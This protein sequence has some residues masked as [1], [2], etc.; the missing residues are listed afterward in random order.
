[1]A[2]QIHRRQFLAGSAT[3]AAAVV[4]STAQAFPDDAGPAQEFYEW[5]TFVCE[6]PEQREV[7]STYV[8]AS[9]L[10]ALGRQGID[11][12][13]VFHE[14][15]GSSALHLLIP[16]KT[17][18]KFG[19]H[20]AALANDKEYLSAAA[21]YLAIPKK[22]APYSRIKSRFMKAFAG[23]PVIEQAE[24]SKNKTDRIFE[25]RIYESHNEEMARRKVEM[26]NQGEIDIMRDVEMAPVFFGETLISDDVPNLTYML[27]AENAE[28]HKAHW[29][30]FLAHPEWDRM[31]KMKRYA[32]TVSKITSI[33]L[34]PTSYSQL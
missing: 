30:G 22:S 2:N 34:E 33:T 28:A 14:I 16:F 23:M 21:E 19:Q 26:F 8:E 20:N 11:R 25:L 17:L 27:S 6:K 15:E 3:A 24:Y 32:G 4:T 5:R 7:V 18:D 10:P 1:M 31:K 9:L 13:G 29:N 12:I